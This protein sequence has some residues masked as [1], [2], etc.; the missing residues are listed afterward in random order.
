MNPRSVAQHCASLSFFDLQDFAGKNYNKV[1]NCIESIAEDKATTILVG[2]IFTCIASDRKL[3]T[4]EWD[5]IKQ[6]IG[7]YSYDEAFKTAEQFYHEDAFKTTKEFVEALPMD[8]R[9][10]YL[11]LCIAVL[12][13]DGQFHEEEVDF[14]NWIIG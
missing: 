9:E 6:F 7:G 2:T 5:F 8:I 13:V 3:S 1:Y 4:K 14:L 10:A 11:S 12:A